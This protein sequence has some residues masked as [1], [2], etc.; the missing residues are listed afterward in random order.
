MQMLL[1]AVKVTLIRPKDT[2]KLG[3]LHCSSSPA[4]KRAIPMVVSMSGIVI[5]LSRASGLKIP[6][7]RILHL[8]ATQSVHQPPKKPPIKFPIKLGM[9]INPLVPLLKLYG[10]ACKTA[11]LTTDD[12]TLVASATASIRVGQKNGKEAFQGMTTDML[13]WPKEQP[14]KQ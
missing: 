1:V 14:D 8:S 9:L 11:G 12:M 6:L 7:L 5:I 10:G 2:N 3:Q 4:P 13:K